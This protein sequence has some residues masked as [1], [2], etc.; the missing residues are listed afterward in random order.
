M[1]DRKKKKRHSPTSM[2]PN[3]YGAMCYCRNCG[4]SFGTYKDVDH[5]ECPGSKPIDNAGQPPR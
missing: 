3:P 5:S 4:K 2:G 1:D